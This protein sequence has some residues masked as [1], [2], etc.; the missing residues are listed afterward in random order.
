LAQ[1]HASALTNIHVQP[2]TTLYC[3]K[4][5]YSDFHDTLSAFSC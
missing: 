4:S 2:T 3:I 5:C 1:D